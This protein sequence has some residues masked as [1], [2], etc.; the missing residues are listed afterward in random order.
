MC[1]VQDIIDRTPMI[2][3]QNSAYNDQNEFIRLVQESTTPHVINDKSISFSGYNLDISAAIYS[4]ARSNEVLEGWALLTNNKVPLINYTK[5]F[6][7]SSLFSEMYHDPNQNIEV[8]QETV[9]SESLEPQSTELLRLCYW[10][11]RC[12]RTLEDEK[13]FETKF[14]EAAKSLKFRKASTFKKRLN[15]KLVTYG[16]IMKDPR[17]PYWER[18]I[19]GDELFK[20]MAL[21][22][23][24]KN[25]LTL[26]PEF[27]LATMVEDMGLK[28]SFIPRSKEAKTCDLLVNNSYKIEIKTLLNTFRE[29]K[30]MEIE[31]SNQ[32]EDTL[33]DQNSID[34]INNALAKNAEIIFMFCTFTSMASAFAK[35]SYEKNMD[36]LIPVALNQSITLAEQNRMKS[37]AKIKEVPLVVFVTY[38]DIIKCDYRILSC[39]I[40]YPV[41]AKD[42]SITE[43]EVDKKIVAEGIRTE[44]ERR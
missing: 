36:F 32:I 27:M 39:M 3:I 12:K 6:Y 1:S 35:Y 26:Y 42:S 15:R 43:L 9:I 41:K 31:L 37:I 2:A 17:I 34:L 10:I 28:V 23:F 22:P 29:H 21:G 8:D 18:K 33:T 25:V 13:S 44:P 11:T 40:A 20:D 38:I 4:E 14:T 24:R 16:R 19:H 7:I 30:E 5:A